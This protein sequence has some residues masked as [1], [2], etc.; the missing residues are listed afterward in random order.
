M[1]QKNKKNN[2]EEIQ[3][4]SIKYDGENL[5]IEVANYWNNNCLYVGVFTD[6]G[7]PY[8]DVTINLGNRPTMEPSFAYLSGDISSE[9]TEV[10]KKNKVFKD[11]NH[12][13]PYNYGV[14]RTI[15]LNIDTLRKFDP[16]GL[17]KA[18]KILN[19]DINIDDIDD[20]TDM[21]N[22][23]NTKVSI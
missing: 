17:E 3:R 23:D 2:N 5:Y 8:A 4:K 7:E 20:I 21:D 14:Y 12:P 15:E 1:T 19:G 10:L 11:L 22:I 18:L 6:D 16:K 13:V 9:L